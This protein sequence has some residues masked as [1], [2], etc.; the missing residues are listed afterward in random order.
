M[1]LPKLPTVDLDNVNHRRGARERI[2]SIL[3]HSFDDS[4]RQNDAEALAGVTPINAA[5]APGDVRRYGVTTADSGASNL[6]AIESAL[7][8]GI[9]I[10]GGEGEEYPI[11]GTIDV[12]G[13]VAIRNLK[14]RPTSAAKAMEIAGT[15]KTAT[16]L[17]ANARIGSDTISVTSAANIAVGDILLIESDDAWPYDQG[18]E[19]LLKG[20]TTRVRGISGTTITLEQAVQCEY[21]VA[22][23]TVAVTPVT[24]AVVDI[25]GLDIG[26]DT[27]AAAIALGLVYCTGFVRGNFFGAQATGISAVSS[28]GLDV[29]AS[30]VIDCY[31]SGT[32]YGIQF[33]SSSQCS[34]RGSTLLNNRRGVD[35]SGGYPSHH[36]AVDGNTVV[37][38]PAEGSCLGGHGTSNNCS[39]TNNMISNAIIGIQGRGPNTLVQGNKFY[40]VETFCTINLAPGQ[41]VSDNH[42]FRQPTTSTLVPNALCDYLVDI[43][44]DPAVLNAVG[45]SQ[46]VIENNSATLTVALLFLGSG[47]NAMSNLK[48]RDNNIILEGQAGGS[49][50]RVIEATT[51]CTFDVTCEISHNWVRNVL[52]SFTTPYTNIT[53]NGRDRGNKYLTGTTPIGLTANGGTSASIST[54]GTIAHGLVAAPTVF[55]VT[56]KTA[57]TD[58]TVAVDATN[59]T[60]TFGGG[61]SVAF[62]WEAKTSHHYA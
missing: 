44:G 40:R 28:Y 34:V 26:W 20:E 42:E 2:N 61:G 51:A 50:V 12:V 47:V 16:T 52:G 53:M 24:P 33:N 5:F 30:R 56:P 45:N 25:D 48:I 46:I 10:F 13:D 17:S 49:T 29:Y 43:S 4:R 3:D 19:G 15:S 54:G 18:A 60:V 58:V 21:I 36:I 41:C 35:I 62:S 39:F 32:G 6:L 38:N 9:P 11:T 27:P 14:L 37:G 55:H 31:V 23:E 59:L 1:P 57:A 22:S 7:S 8:I